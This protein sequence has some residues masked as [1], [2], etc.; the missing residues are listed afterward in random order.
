[1]APG[2]PNTTPRCLFQLNVIYTAQAKPG[3]GGGKA[4]VK[5]FR[6]DVSC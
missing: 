4:G 3:G 1:M 5:E 2:G 6:Q